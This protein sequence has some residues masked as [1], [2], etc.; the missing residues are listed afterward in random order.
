[1]LFT[2]P[3]YKDPAQTSKST[4]IRRTAADAAVLANESWVLGYDLC[5]EPD[6]QYNWPGVLVAD[7]ATNRTLNDLFPAAA[8]KSHGWG[9]WSGSRIRGGGSPSHSPG[10][11]PPRP[12]I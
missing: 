8:D 6:D 1:M 4:V 10:R 2:L 3:A 11:A 12:R 9:E 7:E 5:N